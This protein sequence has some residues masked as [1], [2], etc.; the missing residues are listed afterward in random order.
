MKKNYFEGV[1]TA[2]EAKKIYRMWAMKLHPDHGGD[3]EAFK[4]LQN[5][6]ETIWAKVKDVHTNKDGETYTKGNEEIAREYIDLMNALL[7]LDGIKIE[8]IGCF[9]WVSGETYKHKVALKAA[10][11]KWS[12]SKK[13]WYKSPANYRR[14]GKKDYSIDEIR[15]MYGVQT[16]AETEA[17]KEIA[18]H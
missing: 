18:T 10:G 11:L 17:N 9:V 14:W 3:A 13:M 2:E 5:Q 1:K 15:S 4:E 7:K 6:Y 12:S 8:I 16:S